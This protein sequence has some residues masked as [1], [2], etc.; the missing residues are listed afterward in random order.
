MNDNSQ[1]LGLTIRNYSKGFIFINSVFIKKAFGADTAIIPIYQIRNLTYIV[2]DE[3]MFYF[4]L[5][6]F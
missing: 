2:G 3:M 5:F 1:Y 6:D 4:C